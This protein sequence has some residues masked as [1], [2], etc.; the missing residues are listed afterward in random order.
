MHL[1]VRDEM[2]DNNVT[3]IFKLRLM[4]FLQKCL[5]SHPY[6]II[7]EAVLLT[8]EIKIGIGR[9]I[10]ERES[11]KFI[12]LCVWSQKKKKIKFVPV[13][14]TVAYSV[15][16]YLGKKRTLIELFRNK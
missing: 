13:R 4:S 9:L 6:L 2:L 8:T 7:A 5:F 10:N 15:I 16:G 12:P 14:E 1:L 11:P 3:I